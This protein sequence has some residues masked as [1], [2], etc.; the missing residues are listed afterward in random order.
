MNLFL[1]ITCSCILMDTYLQF[2]IYWYINCLVLFWCLL[3]F[4]S[5][6]LSYVSYVMAPKRKF[7]LSRNPLCSGSSSS[8]SS[9]FDPTPSHIR[10]HD[11]KAKLDFFGNFS[12]HDIHLERQVIWL[13]FSNTDLPTVI[14][15][16][17]G[18]H[19]V[20]PRSRALLWSYR[21]FTLICMD[22]ITLYPSFLIVFRVYAW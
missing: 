3:L 5:F 19:Y 6:S 13:D 9:P 20:V 2:Y 15:N 12:Q 14:Y 21:S 4:L 8:S 7:T 1:H 10:F 17:V 18:S 22:L 11:E 16:I